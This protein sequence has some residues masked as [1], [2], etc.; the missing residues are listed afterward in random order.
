MSTIDT[1][2][3][4][5][6]RSFG[7]DLEDLQKVKFFHPLTLI[8]GPN[9]TGKT[10]II[11]CLKYGAT[12]DT[13]PGCKTNGAFVHDPKLAKEREIKGKVNVFFSIHSDSDVRDQQSIFFL[14]QNG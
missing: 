13:P 6:I 11:E 2:G 9:G 8:V 14:E 3:I 4:Q 5:G 7:P 12:G 1:L 10:T